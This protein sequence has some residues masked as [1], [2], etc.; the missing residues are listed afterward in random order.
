MAAS[1]VAHPSNAAAPER[2]GA[3][4]EIENPEHEPIE[5]LGR[6]GNSD[7]N[8]RQTACHFARPRGGPFPSHSIPFAAYVGEELAALEGHGD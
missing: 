8:A 5:W 1:I 7:R 3:A 4:L 2:N 6:P